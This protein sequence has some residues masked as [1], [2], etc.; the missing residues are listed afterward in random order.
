MIP[1]CRYQRIAASPIAQGQIGPAEYDPMTSP[2]GMQGYDD[3][4]PGMQPGSG[5]ADIMSQSCLH[6][7]ASP[8]QSGESTLLSICYEMHLRALCPALNSQIVTN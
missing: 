5:K 6:G 4:L 7:A 2:R 3:R 8:D 1:P